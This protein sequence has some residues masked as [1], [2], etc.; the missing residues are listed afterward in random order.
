MASN[1]PF[2]SIQKLARLASPVP[3]RAAPSSLVPLCSRPSRRPPYL[4]SPTTAARLA[5][6][7]PRPR[8]G[9]PFIQPTPQQQQQAQTAASNSASSE[10]TPSQPDGPSNAQ[11]QQPPPPP[12][13]AAASQQGRDIRQ[14]PHYELTFTCRPCGTRSRH[15][16][17]K[18]GYHHGTVLIA[19]PGCKSRHVI[20]DHLRIFGDAAVTVED[21]LRQRGE[22][23]RKGALGG[24]GDGG[25]LEFWD[26][27][28]V[29]PRQ[30]W[31]EPERP[32][33]KEGA[34]ADLPPGATF[35]SVK[36]GDGKA[37]E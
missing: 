16:V 20:S 9:I 27:G 34:D 31:V 11:Q 10:T 26:D 37:D 5:H 4:A 7:I 21:I 18:Q 17:S 36:P 25:A 15:R 19:C 29:T 22:S 3:G 32:Q 35:K 14:Q 33:P 24:G 28:T 12:P 13:P 23:V 1:R 2:A 8:N 6:S 30:P